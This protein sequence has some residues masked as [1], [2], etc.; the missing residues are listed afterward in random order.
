MP[1]ET[2]PPP[3]AAT[4]GAPPIGPASTELRS[5]LAQRFGPK[6]G[7]SLPTATPPSEP[8]PTETKPADAP[9]P[10]KPESPTKTEP[11]KKTVAELDDPEPELEETP[12]KPEETI[13]PTPDKE[14][15]AAK[16]EVFPDRRKTEN[17]L[18]WKNLRGLQNENAALRQQLDEFKSKLPDPTDHPK[19]K[20][21]LSKIE[22][23][24]KRADAAEKDLEFSRFE[25]SPRFRSEYLQ[26]ILEANQAGARAMLALDV[27]LADGNVRAGTPED[28][29][30]L[31]SIQDPRTRLT[32]AKKVFGEDPASLAVFARHEGN[33]EQ[34]TARATHAL[35]EYQT[36]GSEQEKQQA[37]AT[38]KRAAEVRERVGKAWQQ[39]VTELME[40][41]GKWFKPIE[42]D[43]EG[44]TL[45]QA[46]YEKT[47]AALSKL[48]LLD[49]AMPD[50]DRNKAIASH[51]EMM[52]KAAA[53]D[54]LQHLFR[55]RG[56]L[57]RQL[58]KELAQYKSSTPTDGDGRG[59]KQTAEPTLQQRVKDRI[60][61][62]RQ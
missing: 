39:S 47:K 23:Q 13:E 55:K 37:E 30:R 42:G 59:V 49:P 48:N 43:D 24:T 6:S 14:P 46:G 10:S 36:K 2:L 11:P 7:I 27:A 57:M 21:A 45:L 12:E 53:Y 54:R 17:K 50:E 22:A 44:N 51:V 62:L 25:R 40:K 4:P 16:P 35:E 32:E 26:P 18:T 58:K 9:A 3:V 52:H 29:Q 19:Y 60:A 28:W 15:A 20:D 33:V 34:L 38:Q 61:K 41:D 8:K 1:T 56:D 31:M 5:R